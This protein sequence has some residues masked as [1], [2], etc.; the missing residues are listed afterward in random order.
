MSEASRSG[1]KVTIYSHR[2]SQ[3]T[4][5][6]LGAFTVENDSGTGSSQMMFRWNMPGVSLDVLKSDRPKPGVS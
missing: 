3:A 2:T 5:T 4:E 1:L 6:V